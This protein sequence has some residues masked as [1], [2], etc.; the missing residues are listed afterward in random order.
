MSIYEETI[1]ALKDFTAAKEAFDRAEKNWDDF[2]GYVNP[3]PRDFFHAFMSNSYYL[4]KVAHDFLHAYHVSEAL[5]HPVY[6]RR[7]DS[8]GQLRVPGQIIDVDRDPS[9]AGV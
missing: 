6:I 7:R 1:R 8:S 2:R 9:D 3:D 4:G 5:G